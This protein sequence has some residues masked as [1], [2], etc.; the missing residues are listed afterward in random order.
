MK[1]LSEQLVNQL[2]DSAKSYFEDALHTNPLAYLVAKRDNI[3]Y[4]L[5]LAQELKGNK[6]LEELAQKYFVEL[7]NNVD[8]FGAFEWQSSHP[9]NCILVKKFTNDE[10]NFYQNLFHRLLRS[11]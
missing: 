11:A 5:N 6:I 3:F 7:K 9:E 2:L 4:K 8:E 1:G 10:N